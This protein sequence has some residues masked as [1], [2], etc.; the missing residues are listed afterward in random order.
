MPFTKQNCYKP[1]YHH[2]KKMETFTQ[3]LK[4]NV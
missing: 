1:Y 2:N 4:G 3:P